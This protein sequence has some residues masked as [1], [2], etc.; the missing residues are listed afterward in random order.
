MVSSRSMVSVSLVD[1]VMCALTFETSTPEF[2]VREPFEKKPISS[3]VPLVS[4]EVKNPVV[5]AT[6]PELDI[7]ATMFR[8]T[9]AP[10]CVSPDDGLVVDVPKAQ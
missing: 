1:L 10:S 5:Y 9:S 6:F 3:Y 8:Y 4:V 2:A 7:E